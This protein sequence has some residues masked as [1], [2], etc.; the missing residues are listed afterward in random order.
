MRFNTLDELIK[1]AQELNACEAVINEAL[2][3]ENLEDCLKNLHTG[4]KAWALCAGFEQFEKYMDWDKLVGGN[5]SYLLRHRP[6]FS[7]YCDW[8]KLDGWDWYCLLSNQP[9]LYKYC[10]WN[11]LNGNNWFYLLSSQP[12]FSKYCDFKKLDVYDWDSLLRIQPQFE[13]KY[14]QIK[15]KNNENIYI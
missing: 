11:R 5:W 13:S 1:K 15:R 14:K 12:Q 7:K 6:K 3:F 9:Q 2:E 4:H 10:Y 8:D